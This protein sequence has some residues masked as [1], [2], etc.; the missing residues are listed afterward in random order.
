MPTKSSRTAIA[1]VTLIGL[2]SL[3]A[4]AAPSPNV[5]ELPSSEEASPSYSAPASPTST[6]TKTP[7]T[8]PSGTG[9]ASPSASP[10]A[11]SRS[12]TATAGSYRLTDVAS[13]AWGNGFNTE[14]GVTI[15]TTKFAEA[16]VGSYPSSS[17]NKMNTAS[18][19]LKGL[20]TSLTVSVGQDASSPDVGGSTHF[21]V[22]VDGAEKAQESKGPYDQ[23]TELT[24]DV[25][26]GN[27]LE[28]LDLRTQKDGHNVW[29][30][31]RIACSQNP[32]PKK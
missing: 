7:S 20:C 3:A 8:A 1:V 18:W 11:T 28:L 31:P 12:S 23:P 24:V 14:D 9:T 29:G 5:A 25:T 10:T 4:C 13:A 16:I 17:T 22:F 2:A 27:R 6:P 21:I 30:S 26:G 19:A 15:Q 32:S